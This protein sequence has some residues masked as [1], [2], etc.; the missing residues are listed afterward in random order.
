MKGQ[1]ERVV[2]GQDMKPTILRPIRRRF[3]FEFFFICFV[4]ALGAVE[5]YYIGFY[6]FRFTDLVLILGSFYFLLMAVRGRLE[7]KVVIL[8]FIYVFYIVAR[9]LNE[10]SSDLS[11]QETRTLFG[12]AAVYLAPPIFFVVRDSRVNRKILISLLVMGWV[13]ALL[14][15]LGLLVWGESYAAGPVN[16]GS[17][18]GIRSRLGTI[19]LDYMETTNAIWRAFS[20]GI[21]LALILA[22]T[23]LRMKILGAC[24]LI[25]QYGG[26]GGGRS[27][28]LFLLVLPLIVF[29]W[30][31]AI[32]RRERFRKIVRAGAVAMVLTIFYLWAPFGYATQVKSGGSHYD[33]ATEVFVLLTGGWS[34][35]DARGGF[36]T[37]TLVYEQYIEGIL[38]SPD[39]FL[40]GTGLSKG[41]AF[42][43]TG[44]AGLAHNM[45]LDVWG[46][47]GAIGLTF[48]LIFFGIAVYDVRGLLR[49][50]S[51]GTIGQ[52]LGFA[53]SIAVLYMIQ[54]MLVQPTTADR[55]FMIVF[56]LASGLLLPITRWVTE[57]PSESSKVLS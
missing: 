45:I 8:F 50:T 4:V 57:N 15:Q 37:R 25:L 22:K 44:L 17:I 13:F 53:Y 29:A 52:L 21:T 51:E 5:S 34:Q 3:V 14:S 36:E 32:S 24:G 48:F 27:S 49:A 10:L 12:M 6:R 43:W 2:P 28:L 31:G 46:L 9:I 30:G 38:S 18:L 42:E 7:R 20:V 40:L 35:A 19:S 39:I 16:L 54:F 55:S 11:V 1:E 47:S 41:A 23:P 56:Y 26:G 33:R